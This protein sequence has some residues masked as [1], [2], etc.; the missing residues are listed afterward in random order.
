[1]QAHAVNYATAV[2]GSPPAHLQVHRS[3]HPPHDS[4]RI[5]LFHPPLPALLPSVA[6]VLRPSTIP[7]LYHALSP[8]RPQICR[9][10]I[11]NDFLRLLY[12]SWRLAVHALDL[13]PATP[14]P[15][16]LSTSTALPQG[17][18]PP[19][20]DASVQHEPSSSCNDVTLSRHLTTVAIS[21]PAPSIPTRNPPLL[22]FAVPERPFA[23]S[24]PPVSTVPPLA[25]VP[26]A[27]LFVHEHFSVTTH[28]PVATPS[29][30]TAFRFTTTHN[31][32]TT[33]SI[34]CAKH[35][36]GRGSR[37]PPVNLPITSAR[38]T[39]PTALPIT[40]AL[41]P[42]PPSLP[43]ASVPPTFSPYGTVPLH[44]GSPRPPST[45]QQLSYT[46]RLPPLTPETEIQHR[47]RSQIGTVRYHLSPHW[48]TMELNAGNRSAQKCVPRW[49][50]TPPLMGACVM[51]VHASTTCVHRD[52]TSANQRR[53][54][55]WWSGA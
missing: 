14:S 12:H 24:P 47:A 28:C 30:P 42:L 45:P 3:A 48:S 31:S 5:P 52:D 46:H 22:P 21:C 27:H 44:S 53:R 41:P 54:I 38:H 50:Y 35:R 36:S 40:S 19:T 18:D 2:L 4:L 29:P 6:T 9:F 17:P 8:T 51:S 49:T 10:Y 37:T 39:I 25:P 20:Q 23:P 43:L 55:C 15:V 13:L 16:S 32:P 1:M 26:G 34:H 33:A 7:G 11:H